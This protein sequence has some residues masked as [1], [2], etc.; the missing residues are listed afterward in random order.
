MFRKQL[1]KF[2]LCPVWTARTFTTHHLTTCVD[3]G[4]FPLREPIPDD[5]LQ[6]SCGGLAVSDR[7]KP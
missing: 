1:T 6:R 2:E 4:S 3:N 5:W 7:V